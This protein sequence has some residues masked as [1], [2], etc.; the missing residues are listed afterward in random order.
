ML[1]PYSLFRILWKCRLLWLADFLNELLLFP[2]SK[3]G[4]LPFAL[5]RAFE[6]CM[7][8]RIDLVYSTSPPETAQLVGLIL[9]RRLKLP[10]VVDY[11]NEWTTNPYSPRAAGCLHA[12]RHARLERCVTLASDRVVTLSPAH[13]EML[14]EADPQARNKYVTVEN[15]FDEDEVAVAAE[16]ARR[17]LLLASTAR[18]GMNGD[19]CSPAKVFTVAYIG[20][21]H[22]RLGPNV[23]LEACNH[24]IQ[25]GA[26]EEEKFRFCVAGYP[27]EI[28]RYLSPAVRWLEYA[29][30]LSH[31]D[32]L[33]LMHEAD[34]LLLVMRDDAPRTLP[35]KLYEY[36]AAGKPI[37]ALAPPD[38]LVAERLKRTRTGVVVHPNDVGAVAEALSSMYRQW[39]EGRLA[40]LPDWSEIRKF[41]RRKMT[42]LLAQTFDAALLKVIRENPRNPR[43]VSSSRG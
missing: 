8:E 18:S 19:G 33:V 23:F 2:D 7:K 13:T 20:A 5:P 38:S 36:L 40:L 12:S 1:S 17:N 3:A 15:G 14:I 21:F 16:E 42:S 27:W 9:N 39:N 30:Y 10:W 29:G 4:W 35:G 31:K 28:S 41:E 37:L 11:R 22:N 34:V 43:F 32:A 6:L 25:S 24:L 26:V